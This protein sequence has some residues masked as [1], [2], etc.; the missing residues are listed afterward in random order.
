MARVSMIGLVPA[1]CGSKRIPH[2]N[3]R[4]LAGHPLIAYTVAAAQQSQVF[5]EVWISTDDDDIVRWAVAHHVSVKRRAVETTDEA[6]DFVWV[7][8]FLM[9]YPRECP[10][11]AILRP[12]APF[13]TVHTIRRAHDQFARS[14]VHS[15]RAV[16]LATQ[17]P[18]K[19][20]RLEN[21][22]LVPILSLM[23]A[24]GTPW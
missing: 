16:E 4:L 8:E 1:R 19:M 2:K 13:R 12:T 6:S 23:H 9:D 10:A 15:I 22:C 24:D 18:G 7:R 14:E 21:G 3:R 17:H 5:S 20:W 11:F